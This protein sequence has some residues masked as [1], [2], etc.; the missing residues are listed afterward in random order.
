MAKRRF[1]LFPAWLRS[2]PTT[3]VG[4][5]LGVDHIQ[6]A[7]VRVSGS[8]VEPLVSTTMESPAGML[9]GHRISA[10][11][12][13]GRAV[14]AALAP[15]GLAKAAAAVALPASAAV[16][17][18]VTLPQTAVE[19][20]EGRLAKELQGVLPIASDELV[21][22]YQVLG[23]SGVTGLD[24]LVIAARADVVESYATVLIEAGLEPAVVDSEYFALQ[25]AVEQYASPPPQG[26]VLLAHVGDRYGLLNVVVAGQPKFTAE[27]GL[28]GAAVHEPNASA[29]ATG[30][31]D[32]ACP[33]GY[34]TFLDDVHHHLH[35]YCTFLR[36]RP[37]DRVVLSGAHARQPALVEALG[38]RLGTPVTVF[39]PWKPGEGFETASS[40]VAGPEHAIAVGLARRCVEDR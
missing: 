4:L 34:E 28:N 15:F 10:P 37:L 35:F 40:V 36:E 39:D 20:V 33:N 8:G 13:V 1:S 16:I 17:K 18:R 21:C 29:S 6:V 9:D 24:V 26:S 23:E 2:R 22:D 12:E 31:D 14:A 11:R 30:L 3:C 19:S 7:A 32:G 25:N 27:I 38:R 5:D